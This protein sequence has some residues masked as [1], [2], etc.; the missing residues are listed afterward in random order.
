M[1][2][3]VLSLLHM[4]TNFL[5]GGFL[6]ALP[7]E[8]PLQLYISFV[9]Y[10]F[11]FDGISNSFFTRAITVPYSHRPPHKIFSISYFIC[12][13]IFLPTPLD[14]F[15]ALTIVP[16][17][18]YPS[19]TLLFFPTSLDLERIFFSWNVV[20]DT[21]PRVPL[22]RIFDGKIYRLVWEGEEEA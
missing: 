11:V 8:S 13:C 14:S 17:K 18:R 9:G 5:V 10:I 2:S 20:G 21:L 4:F 19:W 12:L 3:Q 16:R 15:W 7:I 1:F 22:E 6:L